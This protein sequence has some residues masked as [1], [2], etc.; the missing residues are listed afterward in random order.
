MIVRKLAV[1][2]GTC[3]ALLFGQ[4]A[5]AQTE[6]SCSDIEW[7]SVVTDRYP[8]IA[9]ACDA[10]MEK[11]GKMFA[12]VEV[13]IQRVR[14]RTVTFKILNNDG[15]SGG[16]Y[17]QKVDSNWRASIAGRSYRASDLVRGQKL[18]VYVPSDRWAIIHLDADGPDVADAVPL[19]AAPMLPK[20]ASPLPLF[21]LF[22]GGF[23]LLAAG[24][25]ALRRR[26][27]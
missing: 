1:L 2:A 11:N 17:S 20:T 24:L 15:T 12:R 13:E 22:G 10:V 19:T 18:S 25:G 8:N 14:G 5:A 3:V 9:N 6:M 21:G 4:F 23:I 26:V 27:S 16:S 7:G